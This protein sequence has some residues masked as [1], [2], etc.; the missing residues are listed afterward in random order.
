MMP[1]YNDIPYSEPMG[2]G[3]IIMD[4]APPDG[5]QQCGHWKWGMAIVNT[6]PRRD[7]FS[8]KKVP[9]WLAKSDCLKCKVTTVWHP[10]PDI[11]YP[12]TKDDSFTD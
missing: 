5:C 4:I 2:D 9:T 1:S 6:N 10:Y 7:L 3:M 12:Q 11:P 8:N